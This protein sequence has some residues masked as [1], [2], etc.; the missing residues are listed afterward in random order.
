MKTSVILCT[1]NRCQS[2]AQA[3]ETVAASQMPESDDWEVLIIDNNSKDQTREVAEGFCRRDPARFHYLFEPLQGKSHALNRG[4]HEAH[5]DVLAFMDDDVTVEPNWLRELTK[6][7]SDPEW[8]GTGGRVYLAKDFSP[9]PWIAIEGQHSLLSI[10]ALFDLG[11]ESGPMSIPPI[12]NNMAF[13]KEM[14]VK[15]GGFR[16]DL[17]PSPGSEIRHEDTEFGSRVMKSGGRILYVPSA[18]VRHAVPEGRLKKGYFLAYHYDWGRA[19]VR[20]K[21]NRRPVGIIPRHLISLSN[22]L[23]HVL[24]LKTWWWLRESDPQ[25]RFFNKCHVWAMAGEIVEI[26]HRSFRSDTQNPASSVKP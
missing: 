23:L 24:P 2:L 1:Y 7:L 9:P 21:G 25:K 22:R 26:C 11:P 20:E 5:S 18:V 19:L 14:F 13:R 3:L 17:G 8:A 16:T 6:P 12:G 4:I 15:H 10:L